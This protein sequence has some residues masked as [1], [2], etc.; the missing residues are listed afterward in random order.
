MTARPPTDAAL[1][2]IV[3][4][5]MAQGIHMSGARLSC[6]PGCTPCCHGPFAITELD[7]QRLR[8]GLADLAALAPSRAADVQARVLHALN[9][10]EEDHD[11]PCPVLDPINGTCDL[12]GSRPLICRTFGPPV[13]FPDGSVAVCELCFVGAADAEIAACEVC[14][15]PDGLEAELLARLGSPPETT[16]ATALTPKPPAPS[17]SR[18]HARPSAGSASPDIGR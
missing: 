13:R 14:V 18:C 12:Y 10:M 1:I 8:S 9:Q 3:D 16:V 6:R 5:T 7:A 2:Q 4:A 17:E 15:D 11:D